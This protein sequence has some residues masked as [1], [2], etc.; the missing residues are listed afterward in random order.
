MTS[1][2]RESLHVSSTPSPICNSGDDIRVLLHL[3]LPGDGEGRG[4][5]EQHVLLRRFHASAGGPHDV[6]RRQHD[7]HLPDHRGPGYG[8]G[9]LHRAGEGGRDRFVVRGRLIIVRAMSVTRNRVLYV[10]TPCPMLSFSNV[11]RS[12]AVVYGA[13]T[14]FW[15]RRGRPRLG[16]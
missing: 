4:G 10:C 14:G 7:R 1:L 15:F 13:F 2:L 8:G 3:V 16:V 5:R 12:T 11:V 6:Q 9:D